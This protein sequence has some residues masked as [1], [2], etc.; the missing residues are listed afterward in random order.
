MSVIKFGI[1]FKAKELQLDKGNYILCVNDVF[2]SVD[3]VVKTG[4]YKN[5]KI[6]DLDMI[7]VVFNKEVDTNKVK[8]F[9]KK[10][11]KIISKDYTSD[12]DKT[13]DDL[14]ES[15]IDLEINKL[16]IINNVIEFCPERY[17][18]LQI[19]KNKLRDRYDAVIYDA[20]KE[21]E[22]ELNP[23]FTEENI[24]ILGVIDELKTKVKG[25]DK[26]LE[27]L[28]PNIILN[29]KIIES[30]N[31]DLIKTQKVNVL[32]DGPTGVGKTL[33][34][35]ELSKLL[36]TPVV[37]RSATNY[38]T[39]GYKGDSLS[40]ILEDLLRITDGN[41]ENARKG[42]ICLDEIDKLGDS[43]L[44]IRKGVM[45]ELLTWISGTKVNVTYNKR[46]EYSFDTS[47]L[48]FIFLGAFSKIKEEKP[49]IGFNNT[50]EIK[51]STKDYVDFGMNRE[52]MGRLN[53]KLILNVANETML[54]DII[55]NSKL[56]PLS[57]FIN[58]AKLYNVDITYTE[59]F[60][61]TLVKKSLAT[62]TGARGLQSIMN[63]VKS[64]ILIP[65]MTNEINEF[66]L[67][68]EILS[69]DYIF[70]KDN[71]RKLTI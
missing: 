26:V 59:D 71:T 44:E 39:V 69:D 58:I 5:T 36:N 13:L 14:I 60:I 62:N 23:E 43:D 4:T 67:T 10:F 56:S 35:S 32:L 40:T 70:R 41:L 57:S 16:Q 63:E 1:I 15:C 49:S 61:E 51:S 28:V 6:E 24:D 9:D 3:D 33:I 66:T 20:F 21:L 30:N 7:R 31:L 54:Y 37:V 34:V 52:F 11:Y 22:R 17:E 48:T 50:K 68:S 19:T 65:I 47:L 12:L 8:F 29:Q 2:F 25:Q 55:L 42:I 27:S 45:Q 53:L 38:S 46:K 64:K 18:G